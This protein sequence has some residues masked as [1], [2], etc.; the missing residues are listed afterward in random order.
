MCNFVNANHFELVLKGPNFDADIYCDKLNRMYTMWSR[1]YLA[2]V[3]R[4][5]SLLQQDNT[6]PHTAEQKKR[7]IKELEFLPQ[8]SLSKEFE[9]LTTIFS[10]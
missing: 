10:G 7:N 1:R 2:Q 9:H 3:I 4:K 8:P 5:W 6:K